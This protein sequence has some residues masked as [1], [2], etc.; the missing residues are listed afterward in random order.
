[1]LRNQY[2]GLDIYIK[3]LDTRNKTERHLILWLFDAESPA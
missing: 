3:T 1:M 2:N